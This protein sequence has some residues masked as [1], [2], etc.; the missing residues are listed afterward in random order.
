M[1]RLHDEE[2]CSFCFSR[3]DG[4]YRVVSRLHV[5][6]TGEILGGVEN[7]N[8]NKSVDRDSGLTEPVE[9]YT[10]GGDGRGRIIR[11]CVIREELV[12]DVTDLLHDTYT[13]VIRVY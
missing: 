5:Y 13:M 3:R 4:G 11:S 10:M 6:D 7:G 2:N 9:R 1:S 12:V 8:V